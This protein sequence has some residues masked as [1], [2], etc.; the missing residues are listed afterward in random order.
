MAGERQSDR[1]FGLTMAVVL[2]I[3]VVVGWS[4]FGAALYWAA[5]TS[6][7]FLAIALVAPG[8]L[9]PLNRLWGR[10]AHRV[11][12]VSN[13]LLLGVLFYFFVLPTGLVIRLL[14]RD[15][16]TRKL[17]PEASTYFAPVKRQASVETFGDMF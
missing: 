14:G 7:A 6:V 3:V 2:G 12:Q 1:A 4:L 17:R 11:G 16:T 13:F 5:T 15:P 8:L 9:L 10:V